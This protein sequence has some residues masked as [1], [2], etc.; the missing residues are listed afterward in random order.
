MQSERSL[1]VG[2][3]LRFLAFSK[4]RSEDFFCS[5]RTLKEEGVMRHE[6]DVGR[7]FPDGHCHRN[8]CQYISAHIAV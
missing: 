2:G 7:F 8:D 5:L 4:R 3:Q 1:T 6:Y